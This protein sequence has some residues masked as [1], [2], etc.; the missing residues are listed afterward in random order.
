MTVLAVT[1]IAIGAM[2]FGNYF[3][4]LLFRQRQL[5]FAA[6]HGKGRLCLTFDDGPDNVLTASLMTLLGEKRAKATFFL[7]GFRAERHPDVCQELIK[8]ENE[9][10]CH[11]YWHKPQW[12]RLPWN[13]LRDVQ[14]GYVR[15]K[16][17]I[18]PRAPFRPPRGKMQLLVIAW[19]MARRTK[20]LWWTHDSGDT[21]QELPDPQRIIDKIRSN[22]GGVILM[23]SRHKDSRR[24]D[25]VLELT[26]CLIDL[27][28]AESLT[29]CTAS[30]YLDAINPNRN[31]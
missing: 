16:Q 20:V 5:Q 12:K 7:V 21:H 30:E 11:T 24:R 4:P 10:G 23:H 27:A 14:K 2:L 13:S 6:K 22:H 25:Y 26:S 29:I 15:M 1:A 28:R 17:W 31:I 18:S 8:T 19:L 9:I 3:I